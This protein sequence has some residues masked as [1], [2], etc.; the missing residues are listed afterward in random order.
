MPCF[1]LACYSSYPY[2]MEVVSGSW[3]LLHDELDART[4]SLIDATDPQTAALMR[5]G[6]STWTPTQEDDATQMTS[7]RALGRIMRMTRRNDLGLGEVFEALAW[8]DEEKV[9]I[10]Q[11]QSN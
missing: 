9:K 4:R 10:S 8:Y 5:Y 6:I 11:V 1:L 3:G 2:T 7:D